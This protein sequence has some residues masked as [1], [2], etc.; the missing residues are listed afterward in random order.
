MDDGGVSSTES[1]Y[2]STGFHWMVPLNTS[3]FF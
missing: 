1:H 3:N 2:T